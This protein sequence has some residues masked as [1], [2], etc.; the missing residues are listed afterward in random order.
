MRLKYAEVVKAA[1]LVVPKRWLE[2]HS[3]LFTASDLSS[4][5]KEPTHNLV[6]VQPVPLSEVILTA[7]TN[8]AYELSLAHRPAFEQYFFDERRILRQ[9]SVYHL[10]THD[11]GLSEEHS[12]VHQYRLVM[13]SPVLQG[14]AKREQTQL[15]VISLPPPATS[16]N[17]FAHSES[18]LD[19]LQEIPSD[20]EDV[21]DSEDGFEIDEAFLAG[22]VLHPVPNTEQSAPVETSGTDGHRIISSVYTRRAEPLSFPRSSADD[23]CTVYIPTAELGQIGVLSGD[24]VRVEFERIPGGWWRGSSEMYR[25]SE[26]FHLARVALA[27][28]RRRPEHAWSQRG[29]ML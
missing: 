15:Y 10:T 18:D 3:V 6:V 29:C 21:G 26:G 12:T 28:D 27:L 4:Q 20:E 8:E 24:W 2:Q 9:D 17:G 11:L 13:T 25:A 1:G 23:D 5:A 16:A 19:D 22:S 7:H 14:C